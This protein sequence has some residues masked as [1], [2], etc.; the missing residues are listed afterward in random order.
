MCHTLKK[1]RKVTNVPKT[2]KHPVRREPNSDSFANSL[3]WLCVKTFFLL[4]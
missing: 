3:L 1:G 2:V 4:K